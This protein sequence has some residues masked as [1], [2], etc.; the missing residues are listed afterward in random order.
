MSFQSRVGR[1]PWLK[2]YT[3][4]T[5]ANW[6]RQGVKSVQVVCPGFAVDCL[7]TIEE[8]GDENRERFLHAGGERYE[9]IPALN[10]DDDHVQAIAGLLRRHLGGWEPM[11]DAAV[12]RNDA[13]AI[14]A[15]SRRHDAMA[16][17]IGEPA[18]HGHTQ[19][20]GASGSPERD[21]GQ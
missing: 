9:Y 13:P 18:A 3:D 5:L 2:P 21:P 14:A 19:I 17:Q 7:E 11:E 15:R 16:Q 10:A 20:H 4:E 12:A 1:E 8:I 6:P